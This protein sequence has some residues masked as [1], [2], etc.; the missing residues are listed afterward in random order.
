M[1]KEVNF[2]CDLCGAKRTPT[3]HWFMATLWEKKNRFSIFVFDEKL[4]NDYQEP[5]PTLLCGEACAIKYASQQLQEIQLTEAKKT[6]DYN[7]APKDWI[8]HI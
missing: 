5:K 7:A 4:F 2:Y 8:K 1:G 6:M 3:N